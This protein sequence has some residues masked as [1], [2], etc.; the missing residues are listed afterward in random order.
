MGRAV[1]VQTARIPAVDFWNVISG[2]ADAVLST[3]HVQEPTCP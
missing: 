2:T 3:R 1:S